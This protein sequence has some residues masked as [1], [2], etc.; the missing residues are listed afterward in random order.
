MHPAGRALESVRSNYRGL[1][2]A[3]DRERRSRCRTGGAG[4]LMSGGQESDRVATR[5]EP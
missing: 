1:L 5:F 3:T 4:N 2:A